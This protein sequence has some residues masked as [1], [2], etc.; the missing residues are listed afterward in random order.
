MPSN[1]GHDRVQQ[2]GVAAAV[3]VH[4]HE[5][6]ELSLPAG[7]DPAETV[8]CQTFCPHEVDRIMV[9]AFGMQVLQLHVSELT[10]PLIHVRRRQAGKGC[11]SIPN[12]TAKRSMSGWPRAVSRYWPSRRRRSVAGLVP[13]DWCAAGQGLLR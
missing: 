8:A 10:P 9:E 4:V 12:S 1:Y 6:G 13:T 5:A 11:G 7:A 2:E 3:P